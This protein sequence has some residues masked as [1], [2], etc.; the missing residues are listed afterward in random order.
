MTGLDMVQGLMNG[1]QPPSP[2]LRHIPARVHSCSDG[3]VELRAGID[4]A[5]AYNDI[6][7]AHGGWTMTLLDTAMGLAAMTLLP[8]NK[9]CPSTDVAVR[10]LKGVRAEDGEVRIIGKVVSKGRRLIIAEGRVE[11]GDD[12]VHAWA[13]ASFMII[14]KS[15]IRGPA[16]TGKPT[17]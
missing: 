7:M 6:G 1:T 17:A 8:A 13:S 16:A 3:A 11:T 4:P 5:T 12:R 9:T 15:E 10:F 14:D 2:M